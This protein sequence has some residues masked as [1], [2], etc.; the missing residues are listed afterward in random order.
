MALVAVIDDRKDVR[1][2][3]AKRFTRYLKQEGVSW[4][5]EHF[6]PLNDISDYP[7]WVSHHKIVILIVDEKL[8]EIEKTDGGFHSYDGHD[9]V[10]VIRETNKQLPIYVVTAHADDDTLTQMEGEFEGVIQ[11]DKFNNDE[12][13]NQ[14]FKR[15]VRA[16]QTYLEIFNKEYI[17]LAELSELVALDK[18]SEDEIKELKGLQTKMKIPLSSFINIDRQEWIDELDEKTKELEE[19][20]NKIESFLK[21]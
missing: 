19:L 16:T 6:D 15:I 18:A 7:K 10:R 1:K 13:A 21:K 17:R 14:Q 8:R 12:S 2:R 4:A 11:R 9:L 5:V 3:L 20:S